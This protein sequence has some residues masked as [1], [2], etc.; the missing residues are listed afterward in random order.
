M[1]KQRIKILSKSETNELYGVPR[2]N[3]NEREAYY[4]LNKKEHK[5]MLER[6]SLASKIHFILQLGFF[7]VTSQFFNC[8][9]DEVKMEVDYILQ[10]YF[11]NT[12][13]SVNTIAKQTRH[14]NQMLISK[15]LKFQTDKSIIQKRLKKMLAKKVISSS[16]PVYL[17]HEVLCYCRQ[18]KLMLLGYSTI[19]ELIGDSIICEERRLGDSLK[20]H[21]SHNNWKL[22]EAMISK[23]ENGY[24]IVSLKK[25]PNSFKQKHIKAEIKKIIN[26]E[27]LYKLANDVL[28]K[29]NITNQNICYYASLAEHY[30]INNLIKLSTI[31]QALYVL[32]YLHQRHQKSN[33]NL[34][35]SFIHY[36]EKFKTESAVNAR[37]KIFDDKLE[38]NDD[39]KNAAIVFRFFDDEKIS[40]KESFGDIRKRARKYVKKGN[41]N[42]VADYLLGLLFHSPRMA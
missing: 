18:N 31:K 9:F 41:F 26:H 38:I 23:N 34:T 35:V 33:D 11:N 16:N 1:N 15:I 14:T 7:K 12:I 39:T 2:F 29:L 4:T 20:K 22:I 27:A 19:Q 17:F 36:L 6:G 40:D 3:F 10:I 25:H 30:P 24:D 21:L 32:C 42:V 8:T 37:D 28:P 5:V 13:L